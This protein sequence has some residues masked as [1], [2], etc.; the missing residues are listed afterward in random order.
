MESTL[1]DP[2]PIFVPLSHLP[3]AMF[4]LE[5]QDPKC[6]IKSSNA[7]QKTDF[8]NTYASTPCP[9]IQQ[10]FLDNNLKLHTE[11]VVH[12]PSECL[13][14]TLNMLANITVPRFFWFIITERTKKKTYKSTCFSDLRKTK[15]F[16]LSWQTLMRRVLLWALMVHSR[17]PGTPGQQA[18]MD[19]EN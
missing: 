15:C 5:G 11:R 9:H 10:R 6:C 4:S 1:G 17:A 12:G 2:P 13:E 8:R 16:S 7:S 19:T 18:S 3:S 14:V